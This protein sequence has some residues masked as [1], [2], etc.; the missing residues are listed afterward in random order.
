M[1]NQKFK[2]VVMN[3]IKN[4]IATGQS[5]LSEVSE[6]QSRGITRDYNDYKS[7]YLAI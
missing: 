5:D 1:I 3:S 7:A 4:L 6:A 2:I